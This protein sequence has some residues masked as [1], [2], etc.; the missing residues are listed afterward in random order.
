MGLRQER[1]NVLKILRWL[2]TLCTEFFQTLLKVALLC[3]S[4]FH[5]IKKFHCAIFYLY[6]PEAVVKSVF[7]RSHCC[8]GKL[9]CH[10]NDN[11]M[12]NNGWVAFCYHDWALGDIKWQISLKSFKAIACHPHKMRSLIKVSLVVM[13]HQNQNARKCFE[14]P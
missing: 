4:Q 2:Q 1:D 7:S 6:A 14:P 8:Y 5:V 10:K 11:N 3:L 12:F 13:T 9:L